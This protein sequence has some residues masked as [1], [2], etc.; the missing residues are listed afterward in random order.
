[1]VPLLT[2]SWPY[3]LPRE[4]IFIASSLPFSNFHFR[5]AVIVVGVTPLNTPTV[6]EASHHDHETPLVLPPVAGAC[7]GEQ[8]DR[9]CRRSRP[10]RRD[11]VGARSEHTTGT[12]PELGRIRRPRQGRPELLECVRQ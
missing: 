9:A 4:G 6:T 10:N 8:N 1:M 7:G 11:G 12:E 3:D 5:T 2:D